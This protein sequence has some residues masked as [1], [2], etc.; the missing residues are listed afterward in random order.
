MSKKTEILKPVPSNDG[1]TINHDGTIVYYNGKLK[2]IG[3][4]KFNQKP[5]CKTVCIER[6]K[7]L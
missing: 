3:F 1:L 5:I 7:L 6:K 2:R 4:Q